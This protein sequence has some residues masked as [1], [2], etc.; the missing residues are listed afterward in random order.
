MG[1]EI[2]PLGQVQVQNKG[3]TLA[4]T[5]NA[6]GTTPQ[7][8]FTCP[9]GS[10]VTVVKI[11]SQFLA[12][13]TGTKGTLRVG[14]IAVR[15]NINAADGAYVESSQFEGTVLQAGQTIQFEGDAA[16]N[17]ETANYI[18]VLN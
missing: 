7:V 3:Q 12:F 15:N 9:V 17:N 13:G 14:G 8:I 11:N 2:T 4:G 6:F 10:K 1:F 16:G 5:A 18:F